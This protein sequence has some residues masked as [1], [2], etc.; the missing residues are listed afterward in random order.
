M[1][2]AKEVTHQVVV[3]I[4][5]SICDCVL[6]IE[7]LTVKYEQLTRLKPMEVWVK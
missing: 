6:T 3:E 4:V 2:R 7:G 5:S 1:Q